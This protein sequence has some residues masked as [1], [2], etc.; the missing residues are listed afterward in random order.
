M[1][2]KKAIALYSGQRREVSAAD[3]IS[4]AVNS[5]GYRFS[6]RDYSLFLVGDAPTT[7]A[8]VTN[9]LKAFPIIITKRIT[10]TQIR[11]QVSTALAS[12]LFRFGI[13]TDNGQGEPASLVANT[14]A[15]Q[16]DGNSTAVQVATFSSPVTLQ[17][18]LYWVATA[19]SLTPSLRAVPATAIAQVLGLNP[20]MG[21]N[22]QYSG[23]NVAFTFA[24]LPANFPAGSTLIANTA[25]PLA[26]F[27]IQ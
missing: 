4:D 1:A 12:S 10:I 17:P 11:V 24:T 23:R 19:A 18:G 8:L 15:A 6:G 16:F 7:V 3:E 26:L 21:T 14:D 20:T 25:A 27:R 22:F 13:Y 5:L 2:S 9:T